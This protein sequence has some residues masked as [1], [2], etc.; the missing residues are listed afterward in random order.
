VTTATWTRAA[1]GEHYT[2]PAY[3]QAVVSS[4]VRHAALDAGAIRSGYV[5]VVNFSVLGEFASRE[6]AQHYVEAYLG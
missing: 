3:P 2:H 6:L 4:F 5:A 1:V